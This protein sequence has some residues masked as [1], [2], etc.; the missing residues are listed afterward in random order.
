MVALALVPGLTLSLASCTED[1]PGSFYPTEVDLARAQQVWRDPWLAPTEVGTVEAGWGSNGQVSRRAGTRTTTWVVDNPV[2]AA[3]RELAAARGAGWQLLAGTCNRA[4][5]AL[6]LAKPMSADGRAFTAVAHLRSEGGEQSSEVTVEGLVPHHLDGNWPVP[7]EPLPDAEECLA[8]PDGTTVGSEPERNAE[9]LTFQLPGP[10]MGSEPYEGPDRIGDADDDPDHEWRDGEDA[11]ADAEPLIAAVNDN[12]W[13]R[14]LG[15]TVASESDSA[16]DGKTRRRGPYGWAPLPG[17]GGGLRT[18]A[19]A[20]DA[21]TSADWELT[22]VSCGGGAAPDATLRLVTEHGPATARLG[23]P[24][25]FGVYP[26]AGL[27]AFVTL[28]VPD[29]PDVGWVVEPPALDPDRVACL[30]GE[31]PRDARMVEGEPVTLPD[32]LQPIVSD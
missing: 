25:V 8:D 12:D 32:D 30:T 23:D 24:S 16:A 21:A 31:A 3:R 13:L 14:R 10:E 4:E 6:L 7:D 20:V 9:S 1:L 22:W 17:E 18:L 19:S 2:M 11:L 15:A 27:V 26:S 5:L 28:P 29:G